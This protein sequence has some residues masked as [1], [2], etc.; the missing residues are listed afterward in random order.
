MEGSDVTLINTDGMAFIG[1]GSEWFWTAVS[2]VVL[3]VT[4]IAIY[5]QLR[6]QASSRA[7]E[8]LET[9]TRAADSEQMHRCALDI[10]V[11][12]RDAKDPADIPSAAAG[13]VGG[14]WEK[15]A[16]LARAGH[17]DIKLLWRFDSEGPQGWWLLLA[18]MARKRRLETGDRPN[19]R[20]ARMAG[21][22]HGRTRQASRCAR[23]DR[24]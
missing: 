22:G 15:Y 21:R 2:G 13:V 16:L 17:L 24:R 14:A 6:M 3:A 7:A 9:L 11:A 23:A 10:L 18:P 20:G 12:L 19:P 5:R 4:F 8:Q 1:P